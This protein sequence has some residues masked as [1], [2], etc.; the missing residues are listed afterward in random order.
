MVSEDL[1]LARTTAASLTLPST[2]KPKAKD[3]FAKTAAQLNQ[4]PLQWD[5]VK[6]RHKRKIIPVKGTGA[7]SI[8]EGVA[9]KKRDFWDIYLPNG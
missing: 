1:V 2:P 3:S 8:L 6:E 4:K 5:I 7:P 9:P